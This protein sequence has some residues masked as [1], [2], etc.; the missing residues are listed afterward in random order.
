[1]D[2]LPFLFEGFLVLKSTQ[3]KQGRSTRNQI[4]D[5]IT[6]VD[7]LDRVLKSSIDL[8]GNELI[9]QR[10]YGS[11]SHSQTKDRLEI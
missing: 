1:M 7:C 4:L 2:P 11:P 3:F 9:D 5:G 10:F 8:N 6:P